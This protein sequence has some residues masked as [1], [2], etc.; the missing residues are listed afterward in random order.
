MVIDAE[1]GVIRIAPDLLDAASELLE[2][3]AAFLRT[4]QAAE[5]ALSSSV[6]GPLREVSLAACRLLLQ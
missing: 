6:Q 3:Q 1:E 4:A 5:A 2:A